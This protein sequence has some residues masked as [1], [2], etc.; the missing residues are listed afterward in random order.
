[1]D[2]IYQGKECG[3]VKINYESENNVPI[4]ENVSVDEVGH[5]QHVKLAA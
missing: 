5:P 4:V 2:A 1:M 3:G